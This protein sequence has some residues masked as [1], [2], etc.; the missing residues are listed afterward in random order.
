M[1]IRLISTELWSQ[2]M[3]GYVAAQK[4]FCKQE[5]QDLRRQH[6]ADSV[7]GQSH[8]ASKTDDGAE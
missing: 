6:P 8:V 2:I 1:T 5:E 7:K 4:K 3:G